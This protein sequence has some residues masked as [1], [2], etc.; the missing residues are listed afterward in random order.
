M[1]SNQSNNQSFNYSRY[2]NVNNLNENSKKYN[3]DEKKSVFLNLMDCL[4]KSI[5]S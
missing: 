5:I 1:N 2:I 3:L 4:V